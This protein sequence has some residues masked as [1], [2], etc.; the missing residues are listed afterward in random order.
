MVLHVAVRDG[1]LAVQVIHRVG[2]HILTAPNHGVLRGRAAVT[3]GQ[4]PRQVGE[5]LEC[6]NI[7]DNQFIYIC[8]N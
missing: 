8:S 4:E 1:E 2:R 7:N 5:M 3:I 6:Y